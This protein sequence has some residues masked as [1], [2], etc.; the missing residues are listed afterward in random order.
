MNGIFGLYLCIRKSGIDCD[1]VVEGVMIWS[2]GGGRDGISMSSVCV[3]VWMFKWK[4]FGWMCDILFFLLN[5]FSGFI[6]C[7]WV[8]EMIFFLCVRVVFL[9]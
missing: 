3:F 1:I 8:Y 6:I 9:R 2:C 5:I 4:G 7:Y